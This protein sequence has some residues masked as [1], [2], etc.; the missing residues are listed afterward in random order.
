V[1][2]PEKPART[3]TSSGDSESG[4]VRQALKWIAAISAVLSFIFT[5]RQLV[6]LM[7]TSRDRTRQIAE[8][9]RIATAEQSQGEY[10][11]AWGNL[12][13]ARELAESG[14]QFS[15]LLGRQDRDTRQVDNR[16]ENLAMAWMEDIHPRPGQRF[17]DTVDKIE[18]ILQKGVAN[19]T[20]VR[21]AD[22]LAHIGWGMFLRQR[23]SLQEGDP[24]RLYKLALVEDPQNPYALANWGHWELW[25]SPDHLASAE[26][27]FRAALAAL[28]R[29][30]LY[31]RKIQLAALENCEDNACAA[32]LLRQ[33]NELRVHGEPIDER[34]RNSV[35]QY[36]FNSF[37][38]NDPKSIRKVLVALPPAQ[39]LVTFRFLFFGPDFSQSNILTRQTYLAFLQEAAGQYDESNRT[40]AILRSRMKL[41]DY[42][43]FVAR[44][45]ATVKTVAREN[46]ASR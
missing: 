8:L 37:G 17:S 13:K 28:P 21:K 12:I 3:A 25:T 7:A 11:A 46:Q 26:Q 22:L 43:Y 10:D 2:E 4:T 40:L 31:V 41:Q 27:H 38:D 36:Y 32:E 1:S 45:D 23:D 20:G 29:A 39:Q 6:N 35:W 15:Q 34:T 24:E 42:N 44:I 16:L 18:P 19:A 5:V 9:E 30:R 14:G 33:V